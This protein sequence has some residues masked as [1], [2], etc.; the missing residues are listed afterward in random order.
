[1]FRSK[2]EQEGKEEKAPKKGI[3]SDISFKRDVL[4]N[5]W[6]RLEYFDKRLMGLD[7]DRQNIFLDNYMKCAGQLNRYLVL[8]VL[9][10]IVSY[11]AFALRILAFAEML[12]I[13]IIL[14]YLL[15]YMARRYRIQ[16]EELLAFLMNSQITPDYARVQEKK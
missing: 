3:L 2:E 7:E 14:V 4:G 6:F 16:G 11:M 1:M 13:W 9:F 15:F 8:I 10:M 12:G 5:L